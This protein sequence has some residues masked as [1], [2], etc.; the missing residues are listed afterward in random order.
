MGGRVASKNK[1]YQIKRRI[2]KIILFHKMNVMDL[3]FI[4]TK[5]QKQRKT[6]FFKPGTFDGQIY[7]FG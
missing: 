7:N 5:P 2:F 6:C 4:L 3:N 1:H